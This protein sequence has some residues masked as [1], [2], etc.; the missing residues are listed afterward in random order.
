M[1]C[2]LLDLSEIP[3]AF[4]SAIL[5]GECN[6]LLRDYPGWEYMRDGKKYR[7]ADNPFYAPS[8][9]LEKWVRHNIL[10]DEV[11]E[12]G[13]RFAYGSPQITS[14]GVHT[15]QTR[16]YV[17]QY[18][19]K[20]GNGK[21]CYWQKKGSNFYIGEKYTLVKDYSELELKETYEVPLRTWH[22]VDARVLHS[23]E[24]LND[25][26]I[27]LQV[28]LNTIPNCLMGKFDV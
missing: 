2:E 18:H 25:V 3:E 1:L 28:S 11:H 8:T 16:N 12:V 13:I 4:A 19:L 22:L 27:S 6:N 10:E 21:L 14:A 26:R 17:L 5:A 9:Q 24:D 20:T 7:C 15:D 23:V